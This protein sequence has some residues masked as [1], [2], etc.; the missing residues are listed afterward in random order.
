MLGQFVV[1]SARRRQRDFAIMK[2]LGLLHRQLTAITVWQVTTLT[3]LALLVG[4]PLGVAGGHWAWRIFADNV[5]LSPVAITP[6]ALVWMI[7]VTMAA[8]ILIAFRPGQRMARG[9]PAA[10]LRTE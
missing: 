3:V 1:A 7:P 5:G 10:V 8:A 2:V 6:M 9:S 4:M